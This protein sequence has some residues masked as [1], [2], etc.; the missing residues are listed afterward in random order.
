MNFES[1]MLIPG[2]ALPTKK[3]R[4]KGCLKTHL[5]IIRLIKRNSIRGN[6][7][8]QARLKRIVIRPLKVRNRTMPI[9]RLC[10]GT[11]CLMKMR[12]TLTMH[13]IEEG[14]S[15]VREVRSTNRD[16]F[17]AIKRIEVLE[18]IM[19]SRRIEGC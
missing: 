5:I 10:N 8:S 6:L 18:A 2:F 1:E 16:N 14:V 19:N 11:P 3:K 15:G 4:E 12:N 13:M 17:T 7:E 9:K